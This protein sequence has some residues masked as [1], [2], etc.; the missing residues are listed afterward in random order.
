MARSTRN[1]RL[2]TR[3]AR[4]KLKARNEPYWQPIDKGLSLGYRKGEKG[5][6]WYCRGRDAGR[7]VIEQ[8]G[9]ADD[10]QDSDELTILAYFEAQALAREWSR[11]RLTR[12]NG[13]LPSSL[14]VAQATKRYLSWYQEHRK[15]YKETAATINAHILPSFADCLVNHL[16]TADIKAWHN[17]VATHAARKRTGLGAKQQF[18]K[19]A[20][21]PDEKRARK[22][23]ANRILTVLKAILNKAFQDELVSDDLAW[24]RVKPFENTDEPVTRFL[25]EAESTRLI[26][27]SRPDF[28]RMVK[29]A[30]YTGARYSELTGLKTANINCDT[31]SV[32][33]LPSKSGKGRHIPL[34]AAGLAFFRELVIGKTGDDWAFIKQDG[35]AWGKNHH[36]R[37]LQDA[38]VIAKI[39]PPISF[40]ELRHTYASLLAQAGADLLTISKLLGHADTR[41]TSRH[42][43]HLCDKTLANAVNRFLPS[44]SV[45]DKGKVTPLQKRVV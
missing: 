6:T 15:A 32:F 18:R 9:I 26:N 4:L 21:T 44:F 8:I 28:R 14:T 27:A 24:R 36:V 13:T 3:A 22:S 39:T 38:C 29:A 10:H 23:T 45:V 19:K 7:Y 33:I 20:E 41:I 43:A 31:A 17:K 16:K 1:S 42:Y 40:H 34:S 2:E 12:S 37:L 11:L 30:L 25:T 35:T 5:G